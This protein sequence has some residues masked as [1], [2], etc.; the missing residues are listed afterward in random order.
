MEDIRSKMASI[1]ILQQGDARLRQV[2]EK[3]RFGED[4]PH[5][6][7]RRLRNTVRDATRF[8]Y[9]S[10]GFG[11]A[12]PQLGIM[13]RAF[14][15]GPSLDEL[16]FMCN[17]DFEH[18]SAETF[19]SFEGCLSF[20]DVRGRTRRPKEI[21]VSG[22]DADG[23][24]KTVNAKN[25]HAGLI[26]H[27]IDHLNGVLYSERLEASENLIPEQDYARQFKKFEVTK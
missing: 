17:P 21:T 13:K 9:F 19:V 22:Y 14:V 18:V 10:K 8:H 4:D 5:E 15:F 27:E 7:E 11:L 20:F 25:E 24:I 23:D 1:G 16:I 2:C 3:V 6:I 12:A 26:C